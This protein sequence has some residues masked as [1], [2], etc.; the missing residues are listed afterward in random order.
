MI[1]QMILRR[2]VHQML[3]VRVHQMQLQKE[4]LTVQAKLLQLINLWYLVPEEE[5]VKN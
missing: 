1:Q 3:Q 5:E 2:K 4:V